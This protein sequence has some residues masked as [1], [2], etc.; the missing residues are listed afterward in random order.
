MTATRW[1]LKSGIGKWSDPLNWSLGVPTP[2]SP[3]IIALP[4]GAFRI[5][6]GDSPRPENVTF[7]SPNATLFESAAGSLTTDLFALKAG[8]VIF[9]GHNDIQTVKLTG[10]LLEFNNAQAFGTGDIKLGGGEFFASQT[11]KLTDPIYFVSSSTISAAHG[12]TLDLKPQLVGFEKT[13]LDGDVHFGVRDHDGVIR[14]APKIAPTFFGAGLHGVAIDAGTLI[15]ANDPCSQ[16]MDRASSCTVDD[17]AILKLNADCSLHSAKISGKLV[18]NDDCEADRLTCTGSI[19]GDGDLLLTGSCKITGENLCTGTLTVDH[20]TLLIDDDAALGPEAE[21]FLRD[22]TLKV[23]K[24]CTVTKTLNLGGK[25]ATLSGNGHSGDYTGAIILALGTDLN[26][27]SKFG[28][29]TIISGPTT[30]STFLGNDAVLLGG[31]LKPGG[32]GNA[33]YDLLSRLNSFTIKGG[34]FDVSGMGITPLEHFSGGG[35]IINTGAHTTVSFLS[36]NATTEIIGDVDVV[37][38]G[39]NEMSGTFN[40]DGKVKYGAGEGS[41]DISHSKNFGKTIVIDPSTQT[42]ATRIGHD[43]DG[44]FEGFGSGQQI[45]LNLFDSSISGRH[46]TYTP[47]AT[48]TGG[49]LSITDDRGGY[50]IKFTGNYTLANFKL[51]EGGFGTFFATIEFVPTGAPNA[52]DDVFSFASLHHRSD[53]LNDDFLALDTPVGSSPDDAAAYHF[54]PD[55]EHHF[56][57][58]AISDAPL[59]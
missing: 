26:F 13:F 19:A 39:E 6:I 21:C 7:N 10:G 16:F 1:T 55:I 12:K 43:F 59:V 31:T 32:F 33:L 8:H 41:L 36:A 17:D 46:I 14:L 25:T 29:E 24:D 40:I 38:F 20:G 34:T 42:T 47:N 44:R 23:T 30:Q 18:L 28:G 56:G 49:V 2:T 54:Q 57:V 50:D 11:L 52:P 5:T 3:A 58:H 51:T 35:K 22:A 27:G 48:H 53:G 45:I 4:S 37:F 15:V 9:N